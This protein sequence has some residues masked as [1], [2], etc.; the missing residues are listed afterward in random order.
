MSVQ[1]C[2]LVFDVGGT[3]LRA[4]LHDPTT[5]GIVAELTRATPSLWT[6]PGL[7]AEE[8]R[9]RL[10]EEMEAMGRALLGECHPALVSAALPGPVD[11]QGDVHGCPTIWGHLDQGPFAV[12]AALERTWPGARIFVVNDVTAAGYR[13]LDEGAGDAG[14]LCVLTVSSGIGHKVFIA[15]RPALG[16]SGRGGE[17]GHWRVDLS[18][19][20]PL[21]DCGGRG[22]L[23]AIA[24]GRGVLRA[25][26]HHARRDPGA[27]GRS[28]LGERSGG[29]PDALDNP[30]LAEAFRG[31]DPWAHDV[32]CAAAQPLGQA[33]AAI[34][35]GVG[36]ERFV[37]VGG[38]ALA[39]G[40][41]YRAEVARAAAACTWGPPED[42][43]A[44]VT[45]GDAHEPIGLLGAGRYALAMAAGSS[46][47]STTP[48]AS[49]APQAQ[50]EVP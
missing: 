3:N 21:C 29:D 5:G 18:P 19:E 4:G 48:A 33:L 6:L 46:T 16:P 34:H 35:L 28:P 40:E 20:A 45:L 32:V 43:D 8:L 23:A 26:A 14:S 36:T 41:R 25:A 15:G 47:A 38:F 50:Q 13:Y 10:L 12:R 2:T 31:G 30:A 11:D 7:R 49:T 22:H 27:F 44:R 1:G 24:S 37:L 39:L 42:W 17:I 9:A